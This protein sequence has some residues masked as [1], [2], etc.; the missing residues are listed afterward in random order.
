MT[1]TILGELDGVWRDWPGARDATS[2]RPKLDGKEPLTDTGTW[3]RRETPKEGQL[4]VRVAEEFLAIRIWAF[5]RYVFLQMKNLLSFALGG[6]I[7]ALAAMASY[8][9]HPR[10]TF[11]ALVWI[12][13]I[14]GIAA[15]GTVLVSI[16]RD[17]VLNAIGKTT[18]GQTTFNREFITTM[19]VYV[20]VP[21]LT[22]LATQ[23][24]AIG[25]FIYSVFTPAM[26]AGR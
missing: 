25:D 6:F 2:E 4:W 20:V 22:L 21:L 24:P 23:F 18:S 19:T 13:G 3:I 14:L 5:I 8:P 17:R 16:D 11:M 7:F 10:R 15:I 12:L 9:F 26:K 1:A